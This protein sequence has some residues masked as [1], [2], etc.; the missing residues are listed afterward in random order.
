MVNYLIYIQAFIFIAYVTFLQLK[1][2]TLHSISQS[3]YELKNKSYL[4]TLFCFGIGIPMIFIASQVDIGGSLFFLSGAGFIIVGMATSFKEKLTDI[5]HYTGAGLGIVSALVGIVI[6]FGLWS[7]IIITAILSI[8]IKGF[9][10]KNSIY[11]IEIIAFL[12]IAGGILL[13]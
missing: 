12:A 8:A 4:F 10:T 1:F 13:R 2:G 7:P 5:A 11:W 3:F 9:K 6:S